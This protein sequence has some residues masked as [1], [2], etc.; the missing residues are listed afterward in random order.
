MRKVVLDRPHK[1]KQVARSVPGPALKPK[2]SATLIMVRQD[3][4]KPR[5]L[6]GK[7]H[8]KSTFMPNIFVFPGGRVDKADSRVM[9]ANQLDPAV[10]EKLLVKMRGH[11]STGRA[12]ALAMAAIRETFEETG[13][14]IG[15]EA[16][17]RRTSAHQDW[18]E[19]LGTGLKP[20]LA[21]MRYIA[22]AITPPGRVRRFDSRFFAVDA[23]HVAN[24]DDPAVST[25]ELIETHWLTFPETQELDLAWITRQVLMRLEA[26]LQSREGLLPGGPVTF[27]YQH[28]KKW[29]E[30]TL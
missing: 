4:R 14:I 6:M 28:G 3:G 8:A 29:Y 27:Q 25:D 20:Q 15:A 13:L 7:R 9:P 24:L 19:F 1:G 5:V 23:G 12:R 2:D 21:P 16:E 30:E 26:Q 18:A 17:G 11:P 22:R 10:E